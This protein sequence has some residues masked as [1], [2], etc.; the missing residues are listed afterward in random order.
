MRNSVWKRFRFYILTQS[1]SY[2]VVCIVYEFQPA[3]CLEQ[4]KKIEVDI[5]KKKQQQNINWIWITTSLELI[6]VLQAAHYEVSNRFI[7]LVRFQ[8]L[9]VI[10]VFQI[11][12]TGKFRLIGCGGYVC[13][14]CRFRGNTVSSKTRK[15]ERKWKLWR[16]FVSRKT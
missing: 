15:K 4:A 13:F 16:V 7:Y 1:G 8:K 5:C 12:E 2:C 6:T 3:L 11:M 14:I 9:K 10:N